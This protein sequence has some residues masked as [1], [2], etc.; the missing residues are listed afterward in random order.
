MDKTF[1]LIFADFVNF[2]QTNKNNYLQNVDATIGKL[3]PTQKLTF[4]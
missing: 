2:S 1:G 4:L 3:K